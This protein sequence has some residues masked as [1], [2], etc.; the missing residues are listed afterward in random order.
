MNELFFNLVITRTRTTKNIK[1]NE[2][3]T[4]RFVLFFEENIENLNVFLDIN[5]SAVLSPVIVEK[6]E[7]KHSE[8]N[9]L[10]F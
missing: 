5:I 10:Y 7:G 4:E 3:T 8:V 6:E 1:S 2:R 9:N